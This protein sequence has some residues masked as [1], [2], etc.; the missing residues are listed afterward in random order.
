MAE[1]P[2]GR[3]HGGIVTADQLGGP[4]ERVLGWVGELLGSVDTVIVV[5]IAWLAV[6]AVIYGSA[7]D[8]EPGALSAKLLRRAAREWARLPK[9]FR[10]PIAASRAS[11]DDSFGDLVDAMRVLFRAGLASMLLFCLMFLVTQTTGTWLFML[12][13]HDDRPA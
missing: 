1:R 9:L 5:P 2:Q 12:E 8:P 13:K 3:A 10:R 4:V 11:L 7:I 6:G